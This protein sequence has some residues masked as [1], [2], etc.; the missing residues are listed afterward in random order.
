MVLNILYNKILHVQLKQGYNL[1][2]W[3][4]TYCTGGAYG[5]EYII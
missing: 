3:A 5:F 2:C 4:H 1:V